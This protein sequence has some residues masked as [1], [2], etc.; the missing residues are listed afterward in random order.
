MVGEASW[1]GVR[2]H[3][4]YFNFF[5][6]GCFSRDQVGPLVKVDGIMT[7]QDYRNILDLNM[8]PHAQ[9]KM[10]ADWI[11]QDDNDPKHSSRLVKD[12][13]AAN[14][15]DRMEWPSQSPDL[16]PIEHLWEE[17]DRRIRTRSFRNA[18]ELMHALKEEWDKIPQAVIANLV[19][20]MP[21]RC[22]A[23]IRAKGYS[24]KY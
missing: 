23:V 7:A 17:L 4:C 3:F 15:V 2:H 21:R 9:G 12:W 20:S 14:N 5:I 10:P 11:F 8:I 6:S 18:S 1:F 13:I 19:D 16:N 22:E 24:T